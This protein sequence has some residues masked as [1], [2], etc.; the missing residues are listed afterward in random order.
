MLTPLNRLT[1]MMA[2]RGAV[3]VVAL[4][5]V[6][7]VA[8]SPAFAQETQPAIPP[9]S[10]GSQPGSIT[11]PTADPGSMQPPA[12]S[13]DTAPTPPE[14]SPAPAAP[15]VTS[16]DTTAAQPAEST[17][18]QALAAYEKQDF[19]AAVEALQQAIGADP[20]SVEARY[21]LGYALYKLKRFDESR[22]AFAQAY[23]LRSNYLP[24]VAKSK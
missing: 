19:T 24:L 15:P 18:A 3:F 10:T 22:V 23:Q 12:A 2:E 7:G 21:Y 4:G 16:A 5:V 14:T 11:A 8:G 20:S 1:Q 13:A 6:A 17:L 9:S